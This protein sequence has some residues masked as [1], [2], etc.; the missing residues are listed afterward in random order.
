MLE[1]LSD[2][3]ASIAAVIIVLLVVMFVASLVPPVRAVWLWASIS[4]GVTC[5]PLPSITIAPDV[6]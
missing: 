6:G 2:N 3:R 1:W 4:P 5:L